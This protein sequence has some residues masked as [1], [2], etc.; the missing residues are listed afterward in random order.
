MIQELSFAEISSFSQVSSLWWQSSERIE[1]YAIGSCRRGYFED[2]LYTPRS[3]GLT[4]L[5]NWFHSRAS[6]DYFN[7]HNTF[8]QF[9]SPNNAFGYQFAADGVSY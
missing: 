4:G 7:Q 9:A 8:L 1:I 3:N 6:P 5:S 2:T